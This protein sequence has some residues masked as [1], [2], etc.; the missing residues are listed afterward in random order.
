MSVQLNIKEI[1]EY[2][3]EDTERE[4]LIGTPDRV[5]RMYKEI[6]RG[7]NIEEK[8]RVTVFPNGE[9]G[10]TVDNMIVDTGTYYSMCEHHMM[11]FFGRYTF[12]YIPHHKGLI[13]GLSKVARMVG[14]Y[15]ARLQIQERL[16]EQILN[17]LYSS[18]TK[19]LKYKAPL[20]MALSMKGLHL[21]KTMRGVKN[22]GE[23]TTT[24]LVGMMKTDIMAR[25]EFIRLI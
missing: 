1:L 10:F 24:K 23:M 9:D 22:N 4:G 19:D 6:F 11:P 21:C 5:Q 12:A 20:G 13:L 7:Y 25:N 16:T 2:I 18:L 17:E 3:G 15:S 14:Y 8:P